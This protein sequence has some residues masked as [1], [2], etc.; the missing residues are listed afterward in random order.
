M[1]KFHENI[2]KLEEICIFEDSLVY[3]KT[4]HNEEL[5][6]RRDHEADQIKQQQLE[7]QN[8]KKQ[9]EEEKDAAQVEMRKQAEAALKEKE[10]EER[11]K[12][13]ELDQRSKLVF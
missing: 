4:T 12:K 5:K 7:L 11:K 3:P 2:R 1:Q 8:K 13:E 9:A 6:L 10:E